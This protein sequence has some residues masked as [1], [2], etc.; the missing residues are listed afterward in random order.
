MNTFPMT[1]E[2]QTEVAPVDA[3]A[4]EPKVLAWHFLQ[5]NKRTRYSDELV[6]VGSVLHSKGALVLCGNGLHASLHPADA[7]RYSPGFILCRVELSGE[8]L[9]GED[10][11]CARYRRVIEMKDARQ[12]VLL[13]AADVYK[14]V[15]EAYNLGGEDCDIVVKFVRD[16]AEGKSTNDGLSAARRAASNLYSKTRALDRA[17]ALD[18]DRDLARALALDVKLVEW[19]RAEFQARVEALFKK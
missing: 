1:T 9:H 12:L 11:L 7:Q 2:T 13:F 18:L 3:A 14:K 19:A 16:F 8:M 17:L 10:K 4:E 15:F 5:N 6:E